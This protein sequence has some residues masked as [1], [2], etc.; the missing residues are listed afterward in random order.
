M[1]APGRALLKSLNVMIGSRAMDDR[2]AENTGTMAA[3]GCSPLAQRIVAHL[4]ER[5]NAATTENEPFQHF[6]VTDAFPADVYAEIRKRLPDRERYLPLNIKRWKNAAG[7]STR[8]KLCLTEGEIARIGEDDQPFWQDVTD[9]LMTE[10]LRQAVFAKMPKDIA[11]RLNCRPD[12]IHTRPA[13][14]EVMLVRDYEEYRLKPHPDG[15]PRVVT[16]MFYLA[17]KHSPQDLGTS[18]YREKS[19][20]NR[21]LGKRFEE[22]KRFPFLAN[23]AATFTVN[24][25]DKR[26]SLHGR[27]RIT[28]PAIIRDSIIIAWLCERMTNFGKK[29]DY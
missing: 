12:Q 2:V 20:V 18:V 4:V 11:L 13:W 23:S 26:R 22:V 29:H 24:D 27:E 6:F 19:F 1:D 9:A 25:N 5:V 10:E 16:M 8:D 28:G 21:L 14:P 7:K 15:Y 3:A 17:D